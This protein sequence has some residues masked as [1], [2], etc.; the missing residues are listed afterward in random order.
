MESLGDQADRRLQV[1]LIDDDPLVA[2]FIGRRLGGAGI[3]V[4]HLRTHEQ[5]RRL[6]DDPSA[7]ERFDVILLDVDL[8]DLSGLDVLADLRAR[9]LPIAVVMLTGDDRA[10]TATAALRGGAFH[11]V[12]K[13]DLDQ[14]AEIVGLAAR[15]TALARQAAA[16]DDD[17]G[18]TDLLVG[19]NPA[20][21]RL[22]RMLPQLARS[23]PNVLVTGESGTGK[24]L[25]ARTLHALSPRRAARFV[26]LNCGAI[27]DGLID[28]ELFGHARGAFTGAVTARPGVFA[29]AHRGTL[30][31]DEIGD[32]PLAAQARLL[33]ALQEGEIRPVG[34]DAVREVDV[35]VIAA[36]HVDLAQEVQ[37]GRFRADLYFRLNVVNV[38]VPPLRERKDDLPTLIGALLRRHRPGAT[39]HPDALEV[40]AAHDW[41]GN[42]R[43]L[44]NALLHALALA[45]GPVLEPHALPAA[46]LAGT[47]FAS[48]RTA[49][50]GDE[51]PALAPDAGDEAAVPLT[52]G[53][54][55]AA[56]EF[57]RKYLV[58]LLEQASG[59]ISAAARLAGIDRTNLRRLLQRHGI[60]SKRFR[61]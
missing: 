17:G 12:V 46:L 58:R 37:R 20:M 8:A 4:E 11:Y 39:V 23:T 6:I 42:V 5:I 50:D 19:A 9:G 38:V 57:E 25:V 14:L 28:S 53:K 30:F 33:R 45:S 15:H 7:H 44:E 21:V 49:V 59:S 26:P 32:L 41:P 34:D 55:R 54:K 1:A 43:E 29:Q 27:P 13:S 36:T 16:A 35:W 60:D 61:E 47:R 48:G 24:E 40:L 18:A 31:L 22:R 51:P 52:E 3:A 2:W 10:R 56:A